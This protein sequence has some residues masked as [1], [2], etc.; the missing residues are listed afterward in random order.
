[1][2]GI[3]LVRQR[4]LD[5]AP[6]DDVQTANSNTVVQQLPLCLIGPCGLVRWWRLDGL[7]VINFI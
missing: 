6:K 3:G 7:A 5:H 1:M 2:V 4:A